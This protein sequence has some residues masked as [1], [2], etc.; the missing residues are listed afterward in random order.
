MVIMIIDRRKPMKTL[1]DLE[2]MKEVS[3]KHFTNQYEYYFECLKDRYRA[4]KQGGLDTIKSELSK[5]DKESQL[6]MINKIVN[7]LTISGWY[8]DENELL[9]LLDEK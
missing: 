2:K 5:W 9:H 6:F 7:D 8:F 3:N 4:N 1:Q